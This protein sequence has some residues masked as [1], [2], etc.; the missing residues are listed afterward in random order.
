M[1]TQGESGTTSTSMQNKFQE[2]KPHDNKNGANL[3]DDENGS[4]EIAADSA[5]IKNDG[6][7]SHSQSSESSMEGSDLAELLQQKMNTNNTTHNNNNATHNTSHTERTTTSHTWRSRM[8]SFASAEEITAY[9]LKQQSRK[10][11]NDMINH[12]TS[13]LDRVPLKKGYLYWL[14]KKKSKWMLRWFELSGGLLMHYYTPESELIE[15]YSLEDDPITLQEHENAKIPFCFEIITVADEVILRAESDNEMHSWL[16]EIVKHRYMRHTKQEEKEPSVPTFKSIAVKTE[17]EVQ[18]NLGPPVKIHTHT[19]RRAS[20]RDLPPVT[21]STSEPQVPSRK[22]TSRLKVAR[23]MEVAK[24]ESRSRS[25]SSASAP[26]T[27][28]IHK[29]ST[30]P[31]TSSSSSKKSGIFRLPSLK[32]NKK[33]RAITVNSAASLK[34]AVSLLHARERNV[35][36]SVSDSELANILLNQGP[37]VRVTWNEVAHK[38]P[39]GWKPPKPKDPKPPPPPFPNPNPKYRSRRGTD[40]SWTSGTS[41]TENESRTTDEK[42]DDSSYSINDSSSVS[43]D[44][45]DDSKNDS[46]VPQSKGTRPITRTS[47]SSSPAKINS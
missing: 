27:I 7:L 43:S 15:I 47:T 45:T 12:D 4:S 40:F 18:P 20:T 28:A 5:S 36:R 34:S 38:F 19:L 39:R 37:N 10:S 25:G 33:S 9:Y 21:D 6:S 35:G 11:T 2:D 14:D 26:G 16:N 29:M 42:Y 41:S 24:P 3:K 46:D 22:S 13:L 17:D 23:S 44:V 31:F 1:A 32:S 8:N 30:A